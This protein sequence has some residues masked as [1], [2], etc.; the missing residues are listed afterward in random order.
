MILMQLHL[1]LT[2]SK[3]LY[4]FQ[5][6]LYYYIASASTLHT[7]LILIPGIWQIVPTILLGS[8]TA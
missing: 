4:I 8:G 6:H 2:A 7:F 3:F 5:S 1:R